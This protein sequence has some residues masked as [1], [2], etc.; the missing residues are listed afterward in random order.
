L[1]ILAPSIDGCNIS[2]ENEDDLKD[3]NMDQH[4]E[5]QCSI[6][7]AG[8]KCAIHFFLLSGNPTASMDARWDEDMKWKRQAQF[9][10]NSGHDTHESGTLWPWGI[11]LLGKMPFCR[12]ASIFIN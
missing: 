7:L 1:L 6:A 10:A 11:A 8:M 2:R 5:D 3:A 9:N 12:N 4:R